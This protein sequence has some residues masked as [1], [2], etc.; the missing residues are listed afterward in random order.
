MIS[1]DEAFSMIAD[2]IWSHPMISP[3]SLTTSHD[4]WWYNYHE[5]F[6]AKTK[7][8]P[9][10]VM[11]CCVFC[12]NAVEMPSWNYGGWCLGVSF[13]YWEVMICMVFYLNVWDAPVIESSTLSPLFIFAYFAD[14][15]TFF[16]WRFFLHGND[17]NINQN[18]P[19][20]L[21]RC[22]WSLHLPH[23]PRYPSLVGSQV[24]LRLRQIKLPSAAPVL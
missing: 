24:G 11:S 4:I 19:N 3:K 6:W 17:G 21:S 12:L 10:L 14:I 13:P 23:L 9:L 20:Q 8:V 16:W 22:L 1:H 5:Y 7:K 15:L 2:D 18:H